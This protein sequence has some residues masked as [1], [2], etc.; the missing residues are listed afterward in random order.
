M[1]NFTPS[2]GVLQTLWKRGLKTSFKSGCPFQ[3]TENMNLL[4]FQLPRGAGTIGVQIPVHNEGLARV[5][6]LVA[7]P[8]LQGLDMTVQGLILA[9]ELQS[10]VLANYFDLEPEAHFKCKLHL[11][12][13]KQRITTITAT[14]CEVGYEANAVTSLPLHCQ[15]DAAGNVINVSLI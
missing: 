10:K 1:G 15:V 11:A 5:Q 12:L 7:D 6:T 9:L 8:E 3:Y 4:T 2:S 14:V 13:E